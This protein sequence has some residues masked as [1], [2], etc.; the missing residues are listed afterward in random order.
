MELNEAK[1]ILKDNGY[2]I[3][4]SK[5]DYEY[6]LLKDYF[7]DAKDMDIHANRSIRSPRRK[8]LFKRGCSRKWYI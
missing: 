7:P 4:A 5:Y 2:L 6:E 1:Q 8:R 3:E